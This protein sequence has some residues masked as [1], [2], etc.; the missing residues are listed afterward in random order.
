MCERNQS[1]AFQT[2]FSFQNFFAK[3]EKIDNYS[4]NYHRCMVQPLF[5]ML[6]PFKNTKEISFTQMLSALSFIPK[7]FICNLNF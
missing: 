1:N 5:F 7:F 4:L 3:N 2:I 6:N